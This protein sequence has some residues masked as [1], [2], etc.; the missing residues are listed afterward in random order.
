MEKLEAAGNTYDWETVNFCKD[1]AELYNSSWFSATISVEPCKTNL[2]QCCTEQGVHVM[3]IIWTVY[4]LLQA[5]EKQMTQIRNYFLV[6][7]YLFP[8]LARKIRYFVFAEQHIYSTIFYSFESFNR[9]PQWNLDEKNLNWNFKINICHQFQGSKHCSR[10]RVAN[11]Q[12]ALPTGNEKI[13]NFALLGEIS[14]SEFCNESFKVSLQKRMQ[15]FWELSASHA[16]N[17]FSSFELKKLWDE[18]KL[19][20]RTVQSKNYCQQKLMTEPKNYILVQN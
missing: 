14:K 4:K 2:Q 9:N 12:W 8:H 20:N 6:P 13:I 11:W 3:N 16:W 18:S 7:F 1:F 17:Y 5:A 10:I 19:I 15:N